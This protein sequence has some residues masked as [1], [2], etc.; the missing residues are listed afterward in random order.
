MMRSLTHYAVSLALV[1]FTASF[2]IAQTPATATKVPGAIVTG[3]VTIKG[4]AAPGIV[5]GL[6]VGQPSTSFEPTYKGTTD[7]DGK[8]RI[9]DVAPG[10]YEVAP[11]APAFVVS[12]QA[13]SRQ[14]VVL[15]EGESVD[16]IDFALVRGG[17]ITGKVSD[18]DG[19][20]VVE[21]R[22][23]LLLADTQTNPRIPVRSFSG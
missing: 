20:P 3:K 19:R 21:Q 16:G 9:S 17:V 8:Y 18:A 12:D 15:A 6:R 10:S 2:L 11:V 13:N 5:V 4:K 1:L 7:P 22:V 14:T 23:N